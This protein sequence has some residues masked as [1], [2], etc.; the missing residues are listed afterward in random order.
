MPESM[1][2]K[3]PRGLKLVFEARSNHPRKFVLRFWRYDLACGLC[4]LYPQKRTLELRR[5]MSALCQKQT[6]PPL[7]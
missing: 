1:L 4:P 7:L 3:A 5:V 2:A 6:S